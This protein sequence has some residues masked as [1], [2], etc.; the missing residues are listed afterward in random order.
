MEIKNEGFEK[1]LNEIK[2]NLKIKSNLENSCNN[3]Q[4]QID[5]LNNEIKVCNHSFT[6]LSNETFAN[7][8]KENVIY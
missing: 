4:D 8:L 7:K 1:T 2:N 6:H 5:I 3:M